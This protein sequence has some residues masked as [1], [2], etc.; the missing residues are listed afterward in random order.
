LDEPDGFTESHEERMVR[1]FGSRE[2]FDRVK[3]A[4]A[5]VPRGSEVGLDASVGFTQEQL[6]R[7]VQSS[8][9]ASHRLVLFV[10]Q[11]HGVA[12]S[13]RLYDQL[14]QRHFLQAGALNDR[15]L[16]SACVSSIGLSVA[17]VQA[18]ERFLDD[19]QRGRDVT[20]QLYGR[21]QSLGIDSIPTLFV[22]GQF[23]VSGAAHSS[24]VEEG[25]RRAIARGPS[26]NRAFKAAAF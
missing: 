7:R 2:A 18:L 6:D 14:N 26:G 15:A 13:E 10:E 8:T 20:L 11:E 16:L 3:A 21:A 5:L 22:D 1:K 12:A 23:M 4:H 24:Q 9:L 25:L 19:P 17:Q